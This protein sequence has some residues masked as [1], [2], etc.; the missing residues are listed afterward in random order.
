M[1]PGSTCGAGSICYFDR[2]VAQDKLSP[3]LFKSELETDTLDLTGHCAAG[4]LASALK[5]SNSDAR[6]GVECVDWETDVLCTPAESCPAAGDRGVRALFIN[7]VCCAKCASKPK[8]IAALFAQAK[9]SSPASIYL[10]FSFISGIFVA[11]M[12]FE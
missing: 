12:A 1:L 4:G 2:C 5:E 3:S 10:H 8:E 11:K 6:N 7:H 9:S